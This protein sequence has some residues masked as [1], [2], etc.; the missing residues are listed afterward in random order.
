MESD[1]E[2]ILASGNDPQQFTAIFDRHFDA[3]YRYI[4]RRIGELDADDLTAETFTVAFSA[5]GRYDARRPN[6]LPWLYGIATNLVRHHRRSE[7]RRLQAYAR[8]PV[9]VVEADL[10]AAMDRME[11]SAA[12]PALI[13]ALLRLRRDDRDVLLLFAWA[14]LSYQEIAEA[15]GTPIGTVRSRLNRARRIVRELLGADGQY[16]DDKG[17]PMHSAMEGSNGRD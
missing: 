3:I 7:E 14:D 4:R 10:D 1:A 6:A 15:L 2:V 11:A 17:V 12:V 9:G 8:A 16:Q 5:R 13:D